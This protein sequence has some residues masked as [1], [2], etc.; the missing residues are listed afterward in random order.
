MIDSGAFSV[1]NSGGKI[2]LDSYI[3]YCKERPN[4]SVIVGLDVIPP[5]G[6]KLTDE[7]KDKVATEGWNNYLKM[8]RHLP[9]EKVVAVFHRGDSYKWLEKM[10][11]FG[12]P[13]IG[14]SPRHD[15]TGSDRRDKFLN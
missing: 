7:L 1:W 8:I 10:L 4:L 13:Y 3:K 2:D 6:A 14:L 12:C 5:K 9:M 11:D 15:G